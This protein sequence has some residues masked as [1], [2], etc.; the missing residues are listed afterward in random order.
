MN[1]VPVS[2]RLCMFGGYRG[3]KRRA[4]HGLD[5]HV[6]HM[7]R[8]Q[9]SFGTTAGAN[10]YRAD[11]LRLGDASASGEKRDKNQCMGHF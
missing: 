11:T 5:I 2:E 4:F 3:A 7:C 6:P 10:R 1:A 9:T 8:N